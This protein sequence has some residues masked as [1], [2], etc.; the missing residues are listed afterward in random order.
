MK[1]IATYFKNVKKEMSK[2]RWATRKEM[3]SDFWFI[4]GVSMFLIAFFAGLDVLVHL[5]I[6]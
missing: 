4:S 3:F 2:V 1:K 6:K 5:V